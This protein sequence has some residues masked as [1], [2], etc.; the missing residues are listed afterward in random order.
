MA[1][2][3]KTK[4]SAP[5]GPPGMNIGRATEKA[6]DFKGTIK[7]LGGYLS[8]FKIRIL[9]VVVFAI[10]STI[11]AIV[12]PKILGNATDVLAKG[13]VG[14]SAYE[15][16]TKELPPGV[17]LPP[18]TKGADL[19]KEMPADVVSKIPANYVE[20]L[21]DL[22]F[23]EKPTIDFDAIG[24]ILLLLLGLY[25]LSSLFS[26][27]Q[28]F[29]MSGVTQ[30]TVYKMRNDI[31]EKLDRMPIKYFDGHS[32]GDVLSRVT[33]DIDTISTTLQQSLTQIITSVVT[34]IGVV[35]MMLTISPILTLV[36][37][38][39]LPL[40]GVI[41]AFIAKKSQKQFIANQKEL[42]AI[43]GHIEEMY[44]GQK[45]IKVFGQ[46]KRSI[47]EFEEINERL[48]K[49]GWKSQFMSGIIM[50]LLNFVGNIGYVIVC[51]VGG[52]L[53]SRGSL[54][55]GNIQSFIQYSRSFT[56]PIMQ[57]ASIVNTLQSTAAAAERVFE[58]LDE[59]EEVPEAKNPTSIE[60]LKSDV[61]FKDVT[62]GYSPD[63]ILMK[64]LNIQ[65]KEGQT[66]AVVGPTGAGKTTLVN[67]LM[68]FY[69]LNG[70]SILVGGHDIKDFRRS[71]LRS[72]FGMVL[73]DTW[74]FNGS[75]KDNIAYGHKDATFEEV[76]AAADA[77]YAD[78]FIKT[79][80][81]S[82]ETVIN[83]EATNISQGQKQLLTIARAILADTPI[84]ILDEAT[85]SVDTRTE[86]LIQRAMN[87]LMEGRTSF[88]IAHRLSTIKNADLIL[89]M[90][91]GSIIEQGTHEELMA[92]GEFYSELYNSQ[93]AVADKVA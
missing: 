93:F 73:Q 71:D 26:Y 7:R 36:T 59:A 30:R 8:V 3:D 82:Y 46:E 89:V 47:E 86:A 77:A 2:Q 13:V 29:I 68:R 31:N 19:I 12:G 53:A 63:A 87:K 39:T 56:Q 24:E 78:Y 80:P 90:N 65:V 42:G 48:Y 27:I 28:G 79:L 55:I 58:I 84:L 69:E 14:M 45:I 88:V 5:S 62:F 75:I 83:E 6:K 76:Q 54:S 40:A 1:D 74:L 18:G 70:G 67:L 23:S 52:V 11:F 72:L 57:V 49:A 51:V 50:P 37:V 16:I 34:I 33:N 17:S 64:D 20:Y 60:N 61:E 10:A 9:I 92:R 4:G 22:D 25:A 41:T 81:E 66:V 91:Q 43:N 35:V 38:L 44:T 21:K 15:Q 85:S 32:Y